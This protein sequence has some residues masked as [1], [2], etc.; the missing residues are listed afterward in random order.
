[1]NMNV[2]QVTIAVFSGQRLAFSK[3]LCTIFMPWYSKSTWGDV[4]MFLSTHFLDPEAGW[5]FC[6][7][8]W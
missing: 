2:G 1:M 3:T 6:R 8:V 7:Q 5:E 4:T